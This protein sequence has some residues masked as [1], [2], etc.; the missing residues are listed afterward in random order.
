MDWLALAQLVVGG[1]G[2]YQTGQAQKE[3]RDVIKASERRQD[4]MYG[5]DVAWREDWIEPLYKHFLAGGRA[6]DLNVPGFSE[7]FQEIDYATANQLRQL[8]AQS[9]ESQ[10][11]IVD[12]MTGGAKLRAL[13]EVA[14][15]TAD[16]KVRITGEAA[17]KRRDLDIQLTNEWTKK[18][19][20]YRSGVSPDVAYA[21]EQRDIESA[22]GAYGGAQKD[23]QAILQSLGYMYG[24]KTTKP[25]GTP[26]GTT[27]PPVA[28]RRPP[29][30]GDLIYD[31]SKLPWLRQST[32]EPGGV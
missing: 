16:N 1:Y 14:R 18:A 11:V 21:G 15:T 27:V 2:I 24:G 22:L 17:Q 12:N 7:Q 13:A 26:T 25:T 5:K 32:P 28:T 4:V 23:T 29:S 10:R 19:A 31:P 6:A 9:K 8:G 30:T 20:D 3:S